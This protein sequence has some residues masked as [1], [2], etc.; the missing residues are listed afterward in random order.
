M[1]PLQMNVET[2]AVLKKA[3]EAHRY[4]AEL[5]GVAL[6]SRGCLTI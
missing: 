6:P 5:K 3:A 2:K 1:L 4:L